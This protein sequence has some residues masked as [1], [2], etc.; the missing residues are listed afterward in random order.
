MTNSFVDNTGEE[1][2]KGKLKQ[3]AAQLE[4]WTGPIV[5]ISHVE[6]DGD[7]L[8]STLAL[9]RALDVMGKATTL[10]M[11]VPGYLQ[12]LVSEEEISEPLEQLPENCLLAVLDVEIGPRAI[13][14][15]LEGA[16]FTLNI[17]H[18]GS[19]LRLGDLSCVQPGQAANAQIIKDLIDLLPINWSVDMAT[20]C[21]TGILTDTGN[22]RYSNTN[23]AV[24]K[25]AAELM[26][27]GVDYTV[28]ADRLQWRSQSYFQLLGK[29][30]STIE[31][32]FDGLAAIAHITTEMEN[33]V[34][35]ADDDSNDYVG[36]IRYAEGTKLA[37]FL[38]GR[39]DHTKVSVRSRDGVSAQAI[40]LALGGGGHVAAAGAKLPLLLEDAKIKVLE[41]VKKE[42]ERHHLLE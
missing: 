17:D 23:G 42:L 34:S 11:D 9:K 31:Y 41:E 22:F 6:P 33:E 15:P 4:N 26:E 27:K 32:P 13:G 1:D 36:L 28:L 14:A 29:V 40:C 30:M 39:E 18:H 20:P 19:N 16:A 37:I 21:L 38:K 12:F 8:G 2:Y 25:D 7:A 10:V 35:K 5:L 24:L 3:I